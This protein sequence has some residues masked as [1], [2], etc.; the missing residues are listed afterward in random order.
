VAEDPRT[1]KDKIVLLV[2]PEPFFL[3]TERDLPLEVR[4]AQT[5]VAPCPAP[6]E[7]LI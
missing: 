7:A 5:V 2:S 3:L 4:N 1:V 6:S